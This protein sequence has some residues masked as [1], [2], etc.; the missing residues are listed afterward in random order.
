M[1]QVTSLDT[2]WRFCKSNIRQPR[3]KSSSESATTHIQNEIGAFSAFDASQHLRHIEP[4]DAQ[5]RSGKHCVW[6]GETI[7][8]SETDQ[9]EACCE[10]SHWSHLTIYQTSRCKVRPRFSTSLVVMCIPRRRT[11]AGAFTDTVASPESKCSFGKA[12]R[13]QGKPGR[14]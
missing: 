12:L 7:Q 3:R 1:R 9:F 6:V 4:R 10:C 13:E 14:K 5:N 2:C 8:P 11:S